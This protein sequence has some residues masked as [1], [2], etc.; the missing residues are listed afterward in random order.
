M[1][2]QHAPNPYGSSYA[3]APTPSAS[4]LVNFSNPPNNGV[5]PYGSNAVASG[6][7]SGQGQGQG[8]GQGARGTADMGNGN[9]LMSVP[10]I[11]A[12]QGEF[13]VEG[14]RLEG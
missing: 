10:E 4:G 1:S 9:G 6:S 5:N 2:H 8:Q 13:V 12:V 3:S 11:T 7:G 14:E